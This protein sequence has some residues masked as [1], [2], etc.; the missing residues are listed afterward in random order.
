MM[1]NRFV[2][3]T[4]SCCDLPRSLAVDLDLAVLEFPFTMDGVEHLDDLGQS[5]PASVFYDAMRSGAAPTTAQV[6]LPSYVGLFS[7]AAEAGTPLLFLSFSSA[8]S[9]TYHSALVA[10]DSVIAKYPEADIR[11]VD[12]LLASTAQALLVMGAARNRLAGAGIDDLEAWLTANLPRVNGYFTIDTMEPLRRGGRVSDFAALAGAVLDVKPVL[13]ID[14][15]GELV[16]DRPVRGRKKSLRALVDAFAERVTDASTEMVVVAHG[17]SPDDAAL[18]ERLLAERVGLGEVVKLDVGP[19]I[20][21]HTGP[22][23]VAVAFWGKERS[24]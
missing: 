20:G 2:L 7:A 6:P 23:M 19:V 21:S 4:D 10:R 22:G 1:A 5:M 24:S 9:G 8:L 12:T 13:K 17:D 15:T 18:L 3:A 11:V 16:V 14:A